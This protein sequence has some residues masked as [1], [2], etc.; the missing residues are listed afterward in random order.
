MFKSW[1]CKPSPYDKKLHKYPIKFSLADEH[2]QNIPD[3][4][5]IEHL[6]PPIFDQDVWPC[7]VSEAVCGALSAQNKINNAPDVAS[8]CEGYCRAKEEDGEFNEDGTYPKVLLEIARKEGICLEK[9][10]PFSMMSKPLPKVP[11]KA[12]EEALGYKI[13]GYSLVKTWDEVCHAISHYQ[14]VLFAQIVTT[15]FYHPEDGGFLCMPEG[16]VDGGH[17][18]LGLAYNKNLSYTYKDG[19]TLT[20]FVKVRNS[21]G[22]DWGLKG[23]YFMSQKF[24]E[25]HEKDF[26][27]PYVF[28]AYAIELDFKN[29][30]P[31]PPSSKYYRVQVGNYKIEKNAINTKTVLIN[32]GFNAYIY[33]I[34]SYHKVQV[35]KCENKIDAQILRDKIKSAGYK[36]AFI[37]YY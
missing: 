15:S 20:S 14:P 18:T 35:G 30:I 3:E 31:L 4:F 24:F 6:F 9:T 25:G 21:W 27:M 33:Y 37:V 5:S 8:V 23:H 13:K 32:K 1:K 34:N 10:M 29:P 28:E 17:A 12:L 19:I 7:C 36:S 22:D 26:N 2:L 11:Q 16:T